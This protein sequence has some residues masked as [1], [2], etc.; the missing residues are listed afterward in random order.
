M[1][2]TTNVELKERIKELTCLYEVTSI[3]VNA[4]YNQIDDTLRAIAFS[5]KKAF[6]FPEAT[7]IGIE[8]SFTHVST[9]EDFFNDTSIFSPI[10]VFNE[11]KGKL[12][13]T[14]FN[15]PFK[16]TGFLNEER[17]LLDNVALRIGSFLEHVEIKQS[18]ILFKKKWNAPNVWPFWGDLR[19]AFPN[20][21]IPPL[22]II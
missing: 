12:V 22:S 10:Q 8:T 14:F 16:E 6:Q 11:T 3:I 9:I 1:P 15:E 18:E 5:L 17:L 2:K 13:A 21:F 4:N 7:E 20:G 19:G